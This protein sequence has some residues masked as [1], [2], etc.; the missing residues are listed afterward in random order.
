MLYLTSFLGVFPPSQEI[1][2]YTHDPRLSSYEGSILKLRYLDTK[3]LVVIMAE[4]SMN[5]LLIKVRNNG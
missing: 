4:Y 2:L 3:R 5:Q 1:V